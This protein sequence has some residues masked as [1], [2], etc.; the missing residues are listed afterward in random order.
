V[1]RL[2]TLGFAWRA[3]HAPQRPHS[4]RRIADRDLACLRTHDTVR[5]ADTQDTSPADHRLSSVVQR[6]WIACPRYAR[7]TQTKTRVPQSDTDAPPTPL[8]SHKGTE[9]LLN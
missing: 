8:N 4:G 6:I 5:R 7:E 3:S 1:E 9:K 2:A